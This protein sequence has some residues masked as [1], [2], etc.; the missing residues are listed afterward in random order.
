MLDKRRQVIQDNIVQDV[1]SDVVVL[2]N[3]PMAH[4]DQARPIDL[5][6]LGQCAGLLLVGRFAHVLHELGQGGTFDYIPLQLLQTIAVQHNDGKFGIA[7]H[8]DDAVRV[9]TPVHI[10]MPQ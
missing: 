3:Q 10:E 6:V 9:V 5:R 4:P 7:K 8:I 1:E 2:V